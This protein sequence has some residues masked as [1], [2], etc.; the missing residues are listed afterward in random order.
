[1]TIL[2]S[3]LALQVMPASAQDSPA[4]ASV[5]EQEKRV[6][7]FNKFDTNGDGF[8]ADFEFTPL[9][10]RI[11]HFLDRNKDGKLTIDENRTVYAIMH[12]KIP[13][14]DPKLIAEADKYFQDDDKNIDGFITQYEHLRNTKD[15]FSKFDSNKDGFINKK[16]FL[17]T[18]EKGKIKKPYWL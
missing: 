10:R 2:L 11:F 15:F 6:Q 12:P 13:A 5:T 9:T 4:A 3:F 16:E 17:S 18:L 7:L 8:I 14:D 1:M